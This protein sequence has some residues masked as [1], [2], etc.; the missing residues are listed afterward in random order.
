M[1]SLV[2][3]YGVYNKNHIKFQNEIIIDEI[4]SNMQYLRDN[5]SW[6]ANYYKDSNCNDDCLDYFESSDYIT[7]V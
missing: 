5:Y 6:F 7:T 1:D 2:N 4:V 3:F